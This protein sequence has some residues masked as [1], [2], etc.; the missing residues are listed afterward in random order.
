MSEYNT[1]SVKTVSDA[2]KRKR[3]T[4]KA[5]RFKKWM[6]RLLILVVLVGIGFGLYKLDESSLFRVSAISV[7]DNTLYSDE[8]IIDFLGIKVSDR[9]WFIYNWFYRNTF[10]DVTGIE[11]VTLTKKNNVL[12]VAVNESS[13]VAIQGNYYLLA[14]GEILEISEFNKHYKNQL[15][16][17]QGF[18]ESDLQQRLAESMANLDPEILLLISSVNQVTTTYD[19]AQIHL[20]LHDQKQVYSDFRSL[21]LLNDYPLIVDK[22]TPENNCVYLD[23]TSRSARSA[24][25]D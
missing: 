15:P 20:L 6:N 9:M 17:I 5:N 21:E 2:I 18:V 12:M 13:P 1:A 25:C 19:A 14:N 22:I 24:P 8:D 7:S 10:D 11:S 23:F 16:T 3:K 4:K